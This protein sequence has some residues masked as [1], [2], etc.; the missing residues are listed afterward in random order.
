MRP[1]V[2][3][4]VSAREST[5]E[6]RRFRG[7]CPGVRLQA[8]A[9]PVGGR[10][11]PTFG[12]Y[13]SA[14]KGVALDKEVR[15]AGSSAGVLTALSAYLLSSGRAQFVRGAAMSPSEPRRT[16]P[17]RIMTRAEAL[18]ASGSRYA[19]VSVLDGATDM[20]GAIVG[21]PC[22]IAALRQLNDD[23][24]ENVTLSFFCAGTPSQAATDRLVGSLGIDALETT[25]VR[26]RGNGWPGEFTATDGIRS[27]SLTYDDSWGKHLGRDL[28]WRC[29]ICPDGTGEAADVAVGDFWHADA[30]GYP[31]FD[32]AEGESVVIARTV[33]GH[34]LLIAAAEAGVVA[35]SEVDLDDVER[36]QPL[37][38]DRKRT[39]AVRLLAR[40]LSFK[41]IPSF[42]GYGI[43]GYALKN[44]KL[45]ARTFA[46]TFV[47]SW[48]DRRKG[49][50]T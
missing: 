32:T 5:A 47:R 29:K 3:G 23:D 21:K 10:S 43:L 50:H 7:I 44:P 37:Q 2:D 8:A 35:L 27:A 30:K 15:D 24:S 46:G 1:R 4:E 34:E 42:R 14:W 39:L 12:R 20:G 17:V 49:R 6:A 45:S 18:E 31:L 41:R 48:R 9:A 33:R 26:Y 40:A 25:N 22:E 36:I 38:R 19:P 28:Q 13:M 16:V 11:H